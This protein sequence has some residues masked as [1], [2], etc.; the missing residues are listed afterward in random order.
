MGG[1]PWAE[2]DAYFTQ[3]FGPDWKD[4]EEKYGEK[5][6]DKWYEE[7]D[8]LFWEREAREKK[9]AKAKE[10]AEKEAAEEA[11]R[12]ERAKITRN[13]FCETWL[14]KIVENC[15]TIKSFKVMNNLM[16]GRVGKCLTLK[17]NFTENFDIDINLTNANLG[18]IMFSQTISFAE[19]FNNTAV[20]YNVCMKRKGNEYI[21]DWVDDK[22]P[23]EA[24]IS[25][26]N[27]YIDNICEMFGAD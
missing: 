21:F 6:L 15:F 2:I 7:Q 17:I 24:D 23:T 11:A 18:G 9:E 19:L 27:K 13:E 20:K 4:W 8:R 10:K 26:G 3:K 14:K 16:L 12:L 25:R 5:W 22:M 1:D